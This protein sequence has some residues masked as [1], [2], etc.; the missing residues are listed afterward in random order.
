MPHIPFAKTDNSLLQRFLRALGYGSQLDRPAEVDED[1][2]M[3]SDALWQRMLA[4]QA[5]VKKA[6]DEGAPVPQFDPVVPRVGAAEAAA[7]AAFQPAE[8]VRAAWD[9]KLGKLP[10][11][12]RPAEEA[13]LRAEYA[14]KTRLARDV[15]RPP[16]RRAGGAAAE[17]GGRRGGLRGHACCSVW[18]RRQEKLGREGARFARA[19]CV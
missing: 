9:E 17:E 5:A 16:R 7:A 10:A 15:R 18:G 19:D 14:T 13:A 6:K 12:E 8:E 3:H 2:Q 1:I 4:H 11:D